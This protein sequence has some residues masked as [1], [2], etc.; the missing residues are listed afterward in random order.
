MNSTDRGLNGYQ[1]RLVHQLVRAEYPELVTISRPGFIQIVAYDKEREDAIRKSK[2]KIF[3]DRVARQVGLRWIVEAMAGG[4]LDAIDPVSFIRPINGEPVW[5]DMKKVT[6]EF[7]ELKD[8]LGHKRA[9]LVG[10]N[11]FM[12]LI[13]FYKC[14]FGKLPDRLE[15]FLVIMHKLFPLIV[16]TKY[17]ATHQSTD[18]NVRSGLDELDTDLTNQHVPT[19]ETHRDH[20]K[21]KN[22]TPAHEAGYD[23][24]MTAKVLIRL[25]AKLEGAGHYIDPVSDEE[26]WHTPPSSFPEG[27]GVLIQAVNGT[28]QYTKSPTLNSRS[29]GHKLSDSDSSGQGVPLYTPVESTTSENQSQAKKKKKA[30][31]TKRS[32][33]QQKTA[34]SH[35]GRFDLLGDFSEDEMNRFVEVKAKTTIKVPVGPRA[36]PQLS[37]SVSVPSD[38]EREPEPELEPEPSRLMPAWDSDFWNVYGNKLRVN[39]TVEGVCDLTDGKGRYSTTG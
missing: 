34:F 6:A 38:A 29:K 30:S 9:V 19:I 11:V 16:D 27:G 15:D 20:E 2:L 21:Y 8:Q 22:H 10:H 24:F 37:T 3:E 7:Q 28:S 1:K 18:I 17:M 14:F 33:K 35:A 36:V 12:D 26:A 32:E 4:N 31:K 25:S 39:G 5:V 23:S 13:N